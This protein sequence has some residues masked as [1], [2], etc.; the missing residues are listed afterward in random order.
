MVGRPE[1]LGHI[2]RCWWLP[3]E[4]CFLAEKQSNENICSRVFGRLQTGQLHI[5]IVV[6]GYPNILLSGKQLLRLTSKI[7]LISFVAPGN[8]FQNLFILK[9]HTFVSSKLYL[10][11]VFF[12]SQKTYAFHFPL[13]LI[14]FLDYCICS[15]KLV[16]EKG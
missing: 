2:I 3:E 11:C 6:R 9:H 10:W 5:Y 12:F 4:C 14:L 16:R 15:S 7:V 8:N 13:L 1:L